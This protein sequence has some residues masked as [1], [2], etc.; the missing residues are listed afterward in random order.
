MIGDQGKKQKKVLDGWCEGNVADDQGWIGPDNILSLNQD[1]DKEEVF[2]NTLIVT[3]DYAM[4]NVILQMKIPLLSL[5]GNIIKCIKNYVLECYSCNDVTK[6]LES[7]F[8]PKCGKPTLLKVTCELREDGSLVLFRKKNYQVYQRGK[9]YPIAQP[10]EGR[11][12]NEIILYEDDYNKPKVKSYLQV[13][14]GKI[15]KEMKQTEDIYEYGLGLEDM[16]K[17]HKK[18]KILKVGHGNKNP[19]VNS[20]WKS[21]KNRK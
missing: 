4:Q 14:K 3:N 8:C 1:T 11:R 10:K 12:V 17:S 18:Y 9:R 20:Y 2:H 13:A 5:D 6:K 21:K 7:V 19:N 16:T 15:N